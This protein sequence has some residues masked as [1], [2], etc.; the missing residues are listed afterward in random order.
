MQLLNLQDKLFTEL[1]TTVKSIIAETYVMKQLQSENIK[2][3]IS[4]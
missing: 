2:I 4:D 1:L 3:I